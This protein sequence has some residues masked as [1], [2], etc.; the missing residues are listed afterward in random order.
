MR[1]LI[2]TSKVTFTVGR[3]AQEKTDQN[4]QQRRERN[5]NVPM[6]AVQLVAMDDGGAEVITVTIT[7]NQAPSVKVGQLVNP[8][9]LQAIPW[10]QNGKNGTAFRASDIKA[11]TASKSGTAS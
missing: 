8:V 5:T 3:E 7:A 1:L 9:E 10:A 4:G 6:W 2:D 11:V